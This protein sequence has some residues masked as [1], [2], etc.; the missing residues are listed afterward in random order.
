MER[1]AEALEKKVKMHVKVPL[2]AL[3]S[4]AAVRQHA[5]KWL[6]NGTVV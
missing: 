3:E 2:Q 1:G 5:T 4:G 6:E